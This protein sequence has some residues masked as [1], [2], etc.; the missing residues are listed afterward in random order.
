MDELLQPISDA[1]REPDQDNIHRLVLK[2]PPPSDGTPLLYLPAVAERC[3]ERA[4]RFDHLVIE[5][6]PL[7]QAELYGCIKKLGVTLDPSSYV[8]LSEEVSDLSESAVTRELHCAKNEAVG[9][10]LSPSPDAM[11]G[12]GAAQEANAA[13]VGLSRASSAADRIY[14]VFEYLERQWRRW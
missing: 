5:T 7:W 14:T 1:M 2:G 3:S 6:P 13:A 4:Q 12:D 9:S 8:S 10:A 11:A